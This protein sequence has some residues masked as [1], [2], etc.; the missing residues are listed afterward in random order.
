MTFVLSAL[1]PSSW[2]NKEGGANAADFS[3]K[4]KIKKFRKIKTIRL[5]LSYI[6]Y[7]PVN[8]GI[9]KTRGTLSLSLT[10]QNEFF[11]LY[12]RKNTVV[13]MSLLHRFAVENLL[14]VK[15][16]RGFSLEDFANEV[17]WCFFVWPKVTE[18]LLSVNFQRGILK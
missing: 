15:K 18:V 4:L 14:E 6:K 17:L 2:Q 5:F 3:H 11:Q 16:H 13:G 1:E 10:T 7:E 8:K 9:G 12:S